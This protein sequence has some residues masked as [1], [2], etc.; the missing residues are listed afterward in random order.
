MPQKTFGPT[1][2]HISAGTLNIQEHMSVSSY[3]L[4]AVDGPVAFAGQ[5]D[6]PSKSR[7]SVQYASQASRAACMLGY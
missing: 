4:V 3:Q 6:P 1:N 5:A 7:H 2:I